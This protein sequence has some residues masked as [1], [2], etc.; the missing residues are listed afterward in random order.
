MVGDVRY[1]MTKSFDKVEVLDAIRKLAKELN[2]PPSLYEF[3]K[4]LGIS[5]YQ[6]LKYFPS[7]R[8]A[9]RFAGLKPDTTNLRLEDQDLLQDWGLFVRK[10]RQTPTRDQYR[11]GGKYN[12]R[13]L[14]KH[15]GTWS[16]ISIKFKEFAQD[17]SEWA[18]VLSLLPTTEPKSH[19]KS[20]RATTKIVHQPDLGYVDPS[21][22]NELRAIKNDKFD[23][24]KL[25]RFCEE[26]NECYENA[27]FFAV[28][29]LVRA[30]LDH[31]PPMFE[32]KSFSQVA[33]NYG[34]ST[35]SFKESMQHLENSSRKIADAH[36]HTQIR[37]KEVLPNKTQINFANDLDILLSEIVRL[38]K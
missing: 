2:R 17:K 12:P 25:I 23:L 29:M 3:R 11:R 7:W 34:G 19:Q 5:Q 20:D 30:I 4:V 36:L 31:I 16:S 13:T 21:R 38:C 37:S 33:S 10:A 9:I 28:A 14:E 24:T 15:F 27:H 8:E 26:L 22:L 6:V 35:R 18:D 1:N 32:S